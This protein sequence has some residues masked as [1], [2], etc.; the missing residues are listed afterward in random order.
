MKGDPAFYSFGLHELILLVV[1]MYLGLCL[2]ILCQ[3]GALLKTFFL[4]GANHLLE[5]KM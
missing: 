1:Y 5:A 4:A 3:A 2:S